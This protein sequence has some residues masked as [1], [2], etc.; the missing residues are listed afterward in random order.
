MDWPEVWIQFLQTESSEHRGELF[1]AFF[2]AIVGGSISFGTTYIFGYLDRRRKRNLDDFALYILINE[3][4][5]DVY[6]FGSV[7]FRQL[8]SESWSVNPSRKV[9]AT[10]SNDISPKRI[11]TELLACF[12]SK[13][14]RGLTQ[15]SMELTNFRNNVVEANNHFMKIY[16]DFS[17]RASRYSTSMS[18]KMSLELDSSD[19][20]QKVL[21]IEADM[22]DVFFR[23]LLSQIIRFYEASIEFSDVYNTFKSEHRRKDIS[24]RILDLEGIKNSLSLATDHRELMP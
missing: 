17:K 10:L 4:I 22:I 21:I 5:N 14:S 12:R 2:G 9:K 23:D 1:A 15:S 24:N 20:E 11:P 16:W 19:P 3:V 8:G 13:R 6:A 7:Y 18:S